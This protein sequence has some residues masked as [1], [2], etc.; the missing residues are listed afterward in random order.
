[1]YCITK[2]VKW[3]SSV[4]L[5]NKWKLSHLKKL[6]FRV[7]TATGRYTMSNNQ[8]LRPASG[9]KR[10]PWTTYK[11]FN[12]REFRGFYS[13]LINC[14]TEICSRK[15]K[16]EFWFNRCFRQTNLWNYKKIPQHCVSPWLTCFG[17]FE[18]AQVYLCLAGCRVYEGQLLIEWVIKTLWKHRKTSKLVCI[19]SSLQFMRNLYPFCRN[20][21]ISRNSSNRFSW[22]FA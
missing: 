18:I 16:D 13:T 14:I 7:W 3:G 4:S 6:L 10:N 19:R 12:G 17:F 2:W 1:M 9:L 15:S 20:S 5:V 8:T 22:N 11:V 21:K